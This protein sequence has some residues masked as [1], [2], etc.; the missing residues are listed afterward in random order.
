MA[1]ITLCRDYKCPLRQKCYRYRCKA[2][3]HWQSYTDWMRTRNDDGSVN[4]NGFWDC[5]DYTD[6]NLEPLAE[7]DRRHISEDWGEFT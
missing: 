3:R 2:D 6:R 4:C 5:S 1:D 7:H